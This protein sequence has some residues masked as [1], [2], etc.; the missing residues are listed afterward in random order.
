MKLVYFAWVKA[1]IGVSSEE[2]PLPEGVETAG[3]LLGWLK[4]QG[5]NYEAA[6]ADERAIKIAVNQTHADPSAKITDQDEIAFFPPVTG[7][8]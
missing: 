8:R 7:G 3:E 1:R 4:G 6:F 5:E 2:R